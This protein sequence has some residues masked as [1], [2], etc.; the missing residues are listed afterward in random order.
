MKKLFILIGVLGTVLLLGAAGWYFSTG[1]L[2]EAAAE[3]EQA[4]EDALALSLPTAAGSVSGPV[5]PEDPKAQSLISSAVSITDSDSSPSADDFQVIGTEMDEWL[6]AH[7]AQIVM[8]DEVSGVE[9]WPADTELTATE[10]DSVLTGGL[11]LMEDARSQAAKGEYETARARYQ[12]AL[13]LSALVEGA[14]PIAGFKT[15]CELDNLIYQSMIRMCQELTD[16]RAAIAIVSDLSREKRTTDALP[17]LMR[18]LIEAD[19]EKVRDLATRGG[20]QIGGGDGAPQGPQSAEGVEAR[21]LQAAITVF[22]EQN[23]NLETWAG[24]YAAT[25]AAI[26]EVKD[27]DRPASWAVTRS[28]D[29]GDT[30]GLGA[31]SETWRRLAFIAASLAESK[32]STQSYPGEL[33]VT[34][35]LG[36][37]PFTGEPFNYSNAGIGYHVYTVGIDGLDAGGVKTEATADS[38]RD[39]FGIR[40]DGR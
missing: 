26:A 29:Y 12:G 40:H 22:K 16:K 32:R 13:N 28:F 35:E 6:A 27:D 33:P 23:K 10:Y 1:D 24:A 20:L 36:I 37:D 7:S 15:R 19:M 39:D 38:V 21:F 3:L 5:D 25:N 30:L 2:R 8:W 11:L 4:R 14:H 34:G 31:I 17:G 9:K 18:Q